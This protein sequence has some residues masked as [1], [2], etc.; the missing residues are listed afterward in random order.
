MKSFI[1]PQSVQKPYW[2]PP[3]LSPYIAGALMLAVAIPIMSPITTNRN[4]AARVGAIPS[5]PGLSADVLVG[6]P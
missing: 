5:D 1:A 4:T 2:V 6:F 3:N